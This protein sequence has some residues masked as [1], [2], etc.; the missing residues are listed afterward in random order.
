MGRL[1]GKGTLRVT[2]CGLRVTGCAGGTLRG[3]SSKFNVQSSTLWKWG[4]GGAGRVPI[5]PHFFYLYFQSQTA[6]S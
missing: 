4:V 5:G 6:S 1:T 3:N 2:S